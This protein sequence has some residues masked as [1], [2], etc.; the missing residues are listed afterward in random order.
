MP[1]PRDFIEELHNRNDISEVISSY[2]SLTHHGRV[3]KALCPFH[4]EKTASFTV[5]HD[6]KSFYCFGCNTGGDVISF[7]MKQE[8]LSYI[9]AVKLLANRVGLR[10]P[11]ESEDDNSRLRMRILEANKKAARFF[12]DNLN[13]ENGREVRAYLRKRKIQDKFIAKF[14][15]GYSLSEWSSLR[16]YLR[17]EG[18]YDRELLAA[19]LITEGKRGTYDTFRARMMIPIIDIRGNVIGFGGRTL[20]ESGPKYINTQDT[21]VYKKSRNLFALNLA[22]G[23]TRQLILAEGYMDVIA[24]HQAGF[25]NSVATLG[26]ALTAEQ[27]KLISQYADEVLICYDADEA[28]RR[29]T[30]RAIDLLKSTGLTVKVIDYTG[31]KDPD[32]YIT[33]FGS[34]AFQRLL[35]ES[36]SSIEYELL[37]AKEKYP[38]STE[39]GKV[40]YLIE[41][42]EILSRSTNPTEKD[43][44]AGKLSLELNVSKEAIVEQISRIKR[45]N[46]NMKKRRFENSLSDVRGQYNVPASKGDDIGA[47]SAE[48]RLIALLFHNPNMCETIKEQL[49]ENDFFSDDIYQIYLALTEIIEEERFTGIPCLSEK[50]SSKLM[51]ELT[52][53]VNSKTEINMPEKDTD[54]LIKKMK[55]IS[56]RLDSESIMNMDN[57]E[58]MKLIEKKK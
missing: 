51:S 39:E 23:Q 31:A 2:I 1:L 35:D 4:N 48:I 27:A 16:D 24:L 43:I 55:E 38:V 14:G 36:N 56:N 37:K 30:V 50:L 13:S 5:Y 28:G 22:K 34:K 26:T 9:E 29:A 45:T 11:E 6:T 41:A 18:F 47:A 21:L 25:I 58:L 54:F 53:I 8:N 3:S 33:R 52:K 20:S 44:Y 19:G 49:D 57:G 10:M 15:L 12:Y 17:K 40:R 46:G 42:S 7:V 32:E